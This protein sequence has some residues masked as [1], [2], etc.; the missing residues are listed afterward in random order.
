MFGAPI[1]P[2]MEVA[3]KRLGRKDCYFYE[4]ENDKGEVETVLAWLR[5][6]NSSF[7]FDEQFSDGQFSRIFSEQLKWICEANFGEDWIDQYPKDFNPTLEEIKKGLRLSKH[8]NC[9]HRDYK[10]GII[11]AM[12][13]YEKIAKN[14]SF[15]GIEDSIVFDELKAAYDISDSR[16]ERDLSEL[17][18]LCKEVNSRR[19][20]IED[21]LRRD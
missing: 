9:F 20:L 21:G 14:D 11:S 5:F 19:K 1:K 6:P 7:N 2:D 18:R 17:D 12:T 4:I 15:E 3:S 13:A 8:I 10:K 16:F